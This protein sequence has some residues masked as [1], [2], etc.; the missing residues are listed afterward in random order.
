M[1]LQKAESEELRDENESNGCKLQ[2]LHCQLWKSKEAMSA[3]ANLKH[4]QAQAKD[5]LD[6]WHTTQQIS[7]KTE[8]TQ[9]TATRSQIQAGGGGS[10]Q[11]GVTIFGYPSPVMSQ[12]W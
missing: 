4:E 11:P 9:A 1:E 2:D 8:K 5:Q 6:Q 10:Q 7:I 3:V 12:C